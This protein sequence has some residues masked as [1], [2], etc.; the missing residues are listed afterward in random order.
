MWGGAGPSPLTTTLEVA[1]L[2]LLSL[3]GD[4]FFFFFKYLN[5]KCWDTE[6]HIRFF[7]FFF[8]VREMNSLYFQGRYW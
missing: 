8:F 6:V 1:V 7:L 3:T 2:D 4:L 5:S